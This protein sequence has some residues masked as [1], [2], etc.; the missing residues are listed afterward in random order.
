M[1]HPLLHGGDRRLAWRPAGADL[2]NLRSPCGLAGQALDVALTKKQVENSPNMDTH[3]PISRQHEA[4]YYG[5]YG[6][7]YYWGGPYLWGPAF[8]PA[9]LSVPTT[10]SR[11]ALAEQDRERVDGFASA[12]YRSRHGL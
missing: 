6:Y 4:E 2:A 7:P 8:Y 5:Y 12:Q 9:G 1:G 11:E 3:Q 10:A